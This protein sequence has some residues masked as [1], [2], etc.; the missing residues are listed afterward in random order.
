MFTAVRISGL[1]NIFIAF[2]CT[3][4]MSNFIFLEYAAFPKFLTV[5]WNL[6]VTH[7]VFITCF[8][9]TWSVIYFRSFFPDNVFGGTSLI[10]TP[11]LWRDRPCW[12]ATR[13]SVPVI[14][15]SPTTYHPLTDLDQDFRVR[16][17]AF[18]P[19]TTLTNVEI[20]SA[21][22]AALSPSWICL[23]GGE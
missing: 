16:Q 12:T 5:P 20:I 18:T 22:T 2:W 4:D 13:S 10:T 11:P 7:N 14:T 6:V 23:R 9:I 15:P 17:N 21:S 19:K 3:D 1:G 8:V